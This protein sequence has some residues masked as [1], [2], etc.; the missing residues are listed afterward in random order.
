MVEIFGSRM[1]ITNP[2]LPLVQTDRFLDSPP[3]SRNEAMASFMRRIGVCE[4]RGSGSRLVR[5]K[6]VGLDSELPAA[7][8]RYPCNDNIRFK[9][10]SK[11]L[12]QGDLVLRVRDER[13][14]ST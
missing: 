9:L 10:P 7:G 4:E 2:G 6:W 11:N 13:G 8:K 3:R 12:E 1:E 5:Y 14:D